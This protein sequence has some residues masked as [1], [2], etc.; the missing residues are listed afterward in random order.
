MSIIEELKVISLQLR[1]SRDPLAS[2]IQF[3][4]SEIEAVGKNNGNRF[5]TNDEAVRVI[6]KI[7][8]NVN[9]NIEQCE[10]AERKNILHR[11]KEILESVLPQMVS[12]EEI[13]EFLQKI[14]LHNKGTVMK[15]LREKF[16]SRVNMKR[17][18]EILRDQY[19]M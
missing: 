8:V 18:G 14:D 6:Q 7:I 11:E 9:S 5:T 19:G 13:I 15:F 16:G 1:K 2:S 17:A 10:N 4:I 12:D 3:A